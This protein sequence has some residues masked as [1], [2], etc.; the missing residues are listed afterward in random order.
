MVWEFGG[1]DWPPM[2]SWDGHRRFGDGILAPPGQYDVRVTVYASDEQVGVAVGVIDIPAPEPTP[3]PA[4]TAMPEPET[5]VKMTTQPPLPFLFPWRALRPL[6][7]G[8]LL[9]LV[10]IIDRRPKELRF[11]ST[12][13]W[14]Y[15]EFR[16]E[17]LSNANRK[18]K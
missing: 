8:L 2:I 11:L 18:Y 7:A 14:S 17:V 15:Y 6:M 13:T 16:Q 9:G 1:R 4:A 5:P 12:R 3:I 10:V